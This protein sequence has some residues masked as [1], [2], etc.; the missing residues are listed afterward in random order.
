MWAIL[1]C[2]ALRHNTVET[3]QDMSISSYDNLLRV[4]LIPIDMCSCTPRLRVRS[5]VN[6]STRISCVYF[7]KVERLVT[8][9]NG[10]ASWL[11]SL[12]DP[13]LE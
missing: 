2:A 7:A 8:V 10:I 13:D 4:E 9:G 5:R 1:L 6:S 12:G 3:M 11:N